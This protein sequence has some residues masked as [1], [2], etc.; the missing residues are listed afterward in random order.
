MLGTVIIGK[1]PLMAL[2]ACVALACAC[3]VKPSVTVTDADNGTKVEIKNGETLAVKLSAQLGTGY[4]WKVVSG[5]KGLT[6]KGEPE[7]VSKQEQAPGGPEFQTFKF[8]GTEKGR[9]EIKLQYME[10]WKKDA[11]PL[12]DFIITVTVK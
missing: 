12:K 8:T 9:S 11:K 10:A 5:A 1:A 4:G 2:L 7:Q 3:S 6:L